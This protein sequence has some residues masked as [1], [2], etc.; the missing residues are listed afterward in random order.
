MVSA[1]N[2]AGAERGDIRVS[3]SVT[4][5][6]RAVIHGITGS[7]VTGSCGQRAALAIIG[8][9]RHVSSIN[10]ATAGGTKD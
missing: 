5:R 3:A 1:M 9:R 7:A 8:F 4:E 2:G 10:K 6:D